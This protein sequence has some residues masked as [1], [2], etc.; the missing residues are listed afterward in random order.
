MKMKK[1]F[2]LLFCVASLATFAQTYDHLEVPFEINGV[3]LKNALVGGLNS[4]QIT[5][6]DFNNDGLDDLY[7][8][9]R[10]GDVH[11]TFLNEGNAGEPDYKFAPEYARNF[12]NFARNWSLLYDYNEDG[13]ADL[14][15]CVSIPFQGIRAY[16]GYYDSENRLAFEPYITGNT[17]EGIFFT[18]FDNNQTQVYV[19]PID[20]PV[21]DDID[22]D[23]DT[24]EENKT[25]KS[26]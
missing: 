7:M 14:F 8:F 20:V 19:N 5:K 12:P 21:F 18:Q 11:L 4:P 26:S 3:Q 23:G 16:T 25:A 10:I 6:G 9:D 24:K 1:L 17:N 22:N 15:V 13:I 2:T